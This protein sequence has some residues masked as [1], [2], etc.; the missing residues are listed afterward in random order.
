MEEKQGGAMPAG[1]VRGDGKEG[2][3]A[4]FDLQIGVLP[5][6]V[7]IVLIGVLGAM[8][9]WGKLAA[10]LPTGIALVAVGGFTCAELA[11]R[12]PWIRHVGATS[13]FAAFLPSAMIYYHVMPGA[14]TRSVTAFTKNTNFLY[15]FIAAIIVG[16]VLSM[17]RQTLIRGFAKIFVPVFAGS[18]AAAVVGTGVGT[19]LGLGARHTLFFIVVPIMAGGVGEGALPLSTGY[20]QTLGVPQGP[21][22]AQVLSAVMLGNIVAICCAGALHYLGMKR[23]RWTGDGRLMRAAETSHVV[24]A[25]AVGNGSDASSLTDVRWLAAA[26]ATA[27]ALYLIGELSHQWLGWP[28]PVVMLLLVI[29]AQLFHVVS[30]RVC[31]GARV[32]YRFFSTAVT[33]PLMFAISVAMTPWGEVV[34]AF[35]WANILTAVATVLTL[36]V[37]GFFVGRGVGMHPVEAAMVNATH[38]GLGGTGDVAILTAGNRMALMPFAQIATRIGGA[39]TVMLALSIFAWL[40]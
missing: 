4:L 40:G 39:I 30:P 18:A 31:G 3:W 22:F 6:P 38:S 5:L 11:K 19:L 9:A 13:I 36:V 26:G 8:T 12:I 2:W 14:I 17:D 15:L 7:Y 10:D 32:M 29:A 1:T 24:G 28:A 23:P 34:A 25:V 33:Y 37:T 16:S 20:A 21:L 35:Q 27:I